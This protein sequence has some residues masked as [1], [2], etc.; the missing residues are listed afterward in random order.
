MTMAAMS[1]YA[2]AIGML[3]SAGM[4]TAMLADASDGIMNGMMGSTAINMG[5]MGGM[6]GGSMMQPNAGTS[7]L[8]NAMISFIQSANNKSGLAQQDM[9]VL[10]NKL[11]AST[12]HL[13]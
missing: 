6:M 13:Q 11:M 10:I 2:H 12:G 8:A 4:V 7:G 3:D 5:G 9:Q 1:Q